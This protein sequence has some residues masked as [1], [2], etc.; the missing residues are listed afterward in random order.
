MGDEILKPLQMLLFTT[1]SYG[2]LF[3]QTSS[4][5][6]ETAVYDTLFETINKKRFGL[7]S[8]VFAS[9]KDPFTAQSKAEIDSPVAKPVEIRYT[10]YGIMENRAK[11]NNKWVQKGGMINDLR[12]VKVTNESA[13]LANG[14]RTLTL[15]LSQK[16]TRNV[17]I[18]SN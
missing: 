18:N 3:A 2:L 6:D 7:E 12:L 17:V 14:E 1:L 16:G 11:I 10:L 4:N 13:V 5:K 8:T 15:T 9:I